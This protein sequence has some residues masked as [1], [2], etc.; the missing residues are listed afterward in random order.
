[1][2]SRNYKKRAVTFATSSQRSSPIAEGWQT[3]DGGG[4]RGAIPMRIL[5]HSLVC[6]R[7]LFRRLVKMSSQKR[8][9]V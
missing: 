1:V 2:R 9:R 4:S 8:T 7:A 5:R 6:T 3:C